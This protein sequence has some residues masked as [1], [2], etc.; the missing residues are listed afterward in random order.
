MS[1]IKHGL[2]GHSLYVVWETMK[3]RCNDKN[4]PSY[5]YYG[6]RGI[7][8]CAE[9]ENNF[10]AFYDF[11]LE[12]GWVKGLEIDRRNN[13][14][15]YCPSNCRFVT[16]RKNSLNRR[17]FISNKSGYCGV[18]WR[19]QNMKWQT[20]IKINGESI[21]L[22]CHPT[23]KEAVTARNTY[24]IENSLEHEYKIQPIRHDLT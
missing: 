18:S 24:I 21:Y 23:R 15:G 11:C 19:R 8:V 13:D 2:K 4:S 12:N 6:E 9:W 7:K 14:K 1:N 20:Y 22:G 16:H 5:H 3:S 17:M 10:K